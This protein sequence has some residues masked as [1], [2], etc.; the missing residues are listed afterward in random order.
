MKKRWIPA[1]IAV[2]M[3]LQSCGNG[4]YNGETVRVYYIRDISGPVS[5]SAVGAV[6]KPVSKYA[7]KARVAMVHLLSEPGVGDLESPYPDGVTLESITYDDDYVTVDL[8]EEYGEMYGAELA[9]A[10]ACAV[11]TL[12]GIDGVSAVRFLVKGKPHPLH[13]KEFLSKNDIITDDLSL[14]PVE[15]QAVLYFS[16]GSVEYVVPELKNIIIRENEPIERYIIEELIKGPSEE[17]YVRILDPDTE[18]ISI[19]KENKI[20]Y[21][22]FSSDFEDGF[23]GSLARELQTLYSVTNSLCS[24]EGVEGVQYLV[25]GERIYGNT[26][27][28]RVDTVIGAY[29]DQAISATIYMV[30]RTGQ[31]LVKIPARIRTDS[32]FYIERLIVE[33]LITGVDGFGFMSMIPKGTMLLGMEIDKDTCVINFSQE[34]TAND[35]GA[36]D[37]EI[38]FQALALSLKDA[39]ENI[40]KI[41]VK[42]NG[43]DITDGAAIYPDRS[44]VKGG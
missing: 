36:V 12:C 20:C 5:E 42:V 40:S 38:I 28:R 32:G 19:S 17:D 4:R 16:E 8:S 23:K 11:M 14:K 34:F 33:T 35:S 1:F 27:M 21:V 9:A 10:D 30:D 29:S 24:A 18:L 39:N 26:V 2:I 43:I 22:N 25:E 7:D 6:D 44:I 3:M 41:Q 13:E 15:M 37:R 31:N